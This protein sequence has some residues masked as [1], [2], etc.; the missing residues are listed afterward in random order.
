MNTEVQPKKE[1]RSIRMISLNEVMQKTALSKSTIYAKRNPR[2]ALGRY[3]PTFPVPIRM[4]LNRVAWVENEVDAW[5]E[6]R[7]AARDAGVQE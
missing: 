6:A 7:I 2:D 3:D 1:R 5:L 4:S